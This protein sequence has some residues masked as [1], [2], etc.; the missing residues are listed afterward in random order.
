MWREINIEN[1]KIEKV[2]GEFFLW[3]PINYPFFK[4]RIK[5]YENSKCKFRGTTDIALKRKST[6]EFEQAS[7]YGGNVEEAL[8][9]VI[10]DF[11]QM[12]KEEGIENINQKDIRYVKW[13][14]F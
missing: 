14:N 8:I 7:G 9:N 3:M 13:I 12:I 4:L 5:I 1:I 2:V 6:G 11:D 10:K